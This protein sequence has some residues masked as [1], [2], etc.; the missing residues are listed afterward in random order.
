MDGHLRFISLKHST[1]GQNIQNFFN[2]K[3]CGRIEIKTVE[4][5]LRFIYN[6]KCVFDKTDKRQSQTVFQKSFLQS[7]PSEVTEDCVRNA[8][9][10]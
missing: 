1:S 5:D 2:I 6:K 8:T 7:V 10:K 4:R 9:S 3:F